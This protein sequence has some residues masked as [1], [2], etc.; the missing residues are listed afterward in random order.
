MLKQLPLVL[1]V[2]PEHSNFFRQLWEMLQA[3]SS[4]NW[5]ALIMGLCTFFTLQLTQRYK[6]IPVALLLIILGISF[7]VMGYTHA[8]AICSVEHFELRYTEYSFASVEYE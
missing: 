8:W 7:N 3:Y 4:W 6:T 1:Q 5:H 2:H